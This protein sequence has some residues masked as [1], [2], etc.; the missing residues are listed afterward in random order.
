MDQNTKSPKRVPVGA[1]ELQ[2]AG[3][4]IIPKLNDKSVVGLFRRYEALFE[5]LANMD[6]QER[7]IN[8]LFLA[9]LMLTSYAKKSQSVADKKQIF[10]KKNEV[11]F[12]IANDPEMRRKV[13]FK[14]LVS[15]NFRVTSFCKAC[16]AKNTEE[17]ID[18]HK[19]KFCEKCNVDRSFYNVL[20]MH[21]KFKDGSATLFLSNDL[22]KNVRGLKLKSKGKLEDFDEEATYDKFHYNVRNLDA[23][24]IASVLELHFRLMKGDVG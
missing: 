20:S 18:R 6:R 21:H 9:G 10:T 16:E 3:D 1:I 5:T 14:Y 22:I 7:R 13:A 12:K 2:F 23:I 11:Y 8:Y 19:W 15:S 24:S 17:K 4:L